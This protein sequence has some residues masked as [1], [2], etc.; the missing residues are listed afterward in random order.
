MDKSK[1]KILPSTILFAVLLILSL[2]FIGELMISG[3]SKKKSTVTAV[4]SDVWFSSDK[5]KVK[6]GESFDVAVYIN[7]KGKQI[8]AF[9]FDFNF[10]QKDM[11]VDI[12]SGKDGLDKGLDSGNF[13]L[14]SNPNDVAS[15]HFRFSGICAQDC[16]NGEGKYLAIV[17]AK[18]KT[19][20]NFA[21]M[22]NSLKVKEL[23]ND[24]GKA[25]AFE[26][27]AGAITIK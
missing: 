19:D 11:T 5:E 18:A 15:G 17:H 12:A 14:L 3:N 16:V 13:I 2:V 4:N 23:T 24:L 6:A 20:I 27:K 21:D 1:Y 10:N 22:G 7:T 25:I 8:G 26:D 9:A